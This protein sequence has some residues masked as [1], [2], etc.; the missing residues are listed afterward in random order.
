MPRRLVI[1]TVAGL[2]IAVTLGLVQLIR[3]MTAAGVFLLVVPALATGANVVLIKHSLARA[4]PGA[5]RRRGA[6]P[7]DG[8]R[9]PPPDH[10]LLTRKLAWTGMRQHGGGDGNERQV[11]ARGAGAAGKHAHAAVP[12]E[13]IGAVVQARVASL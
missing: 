3:G 1:M 12:P 9:H 13:A 4:Q 10:W 6:A 8:W 11:T 5:P 7:D 2:V